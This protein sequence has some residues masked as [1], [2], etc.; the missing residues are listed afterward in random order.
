[1]S[2]LWN[3]VFCAVLDAGGHP[4]WAY[5]DDNAHGGRGLSLERRSFQMT[6]VVACLA[7]DARNPLQAGWRPRQ[8]MVTE[9]LGCSAPKKIR[10]SRV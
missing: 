8:G 1:M 3:A 7:R 6:G 9:R 5:R 10:L 2:A 4:F